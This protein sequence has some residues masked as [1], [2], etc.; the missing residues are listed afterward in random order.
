MAV[1]RP[2]LRAAPSSGHESAAP[3]A[4]ET[5]AAS[6]RSQAALRPSAVLQLPRPRHLLRLALAAPLGPRPSDGPSATPLLALLTLLATLLAAAAPPLAVLVSGV[7]L[8]VVVDVFTD[9]E[10]S[11]RRRATS[12][13]T[14]VGV[15]LFAQWALRA[16]CSLLTCVLLPHPDPYSVAK[17][18]G[19][20]LLPGPVCAD[21]Q[22]LEPPTEILVLWVALQ[23]ASARTRP[24]ASGSVGTLVGPSAA[25][26]FLSHL[27]GGVCALVGGPRRPSPNAAPLNAHTCRDGRVPDLNSPCCDGS[28]SSVA[29]PQHPVKMRRTSLPAISVQRPTSSQVSRRSR[30]AR[31]LAPSPGN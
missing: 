7:A 29:S 30:R 27:L 22:L 17:A 23:V 18:A 8:V 13:L 3:A 5:P 12:L 31:S 15:V 20:S 11:L 25:R 21:Q 9:A 16:C 6:R 24:R 10:A 28:A 2:C 4:C 14:R 26:P 19:S 1:R